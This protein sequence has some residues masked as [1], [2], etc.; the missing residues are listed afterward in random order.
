[1]MKTIFQIT[2]LC[3]SLCLAPG[4]RA[5]GGVSVAQS[6]AATCAN[7]HGTNGRLPLQND[8]PSLAGRSAEWIRQQVIDFR[9]YGRASTVMQQIVRGYSDAEI[10]LIAH[11]L[12]NNGG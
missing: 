11:W 2:F 12:A 1:M 10:E 6:L 9:N 7:C 4:V 8:V 5:Q 3:A